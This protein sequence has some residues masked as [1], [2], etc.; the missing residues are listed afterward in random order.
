MKHIVYPMS[1]IVGQEAAKRALLLALVNP[2]AGGLLLSGAQGTAKTLLARAAG[3]LPQV[4]RLTQLPLG[5]TDDMV[6]GGADIERLLVDGVRAAQAGILQRA[7]GG[8]LL[9]DEANLLPRPF[10]HAALAAAA[11]D[12]SLVLVGTMNP[13]EGT[14]PA[15]V[16]DGFG[17]FVSLSGA[18]DAAER[19]AIVRRACAYSRA[20]EAFAAD[21]RAADEELG[22][23]V[24]AAR[25]RLADVVVS[26]A[27]RTLAAEFVVRARCA[28]NRAELF[29]TEAARAAAALAGRSYLLPADMEEAALY[30]LPHRMSA[31][32]EMPAPPPTAEESEGDGGQD[33]DDTPQE[34]QGQD[35]PQGDSPDAGDTAEED[36]HADESPTEEP[37]EES[38]DEGGDAD[39]TAPPPPAGA[40]MDT[41]FD[42]L[43]RMTMPLLDFAA[44]LRA[45]GTGSGKR[46]TAASAAGGRMVRDAAARERER[47]IALA[48]TLR[49]A[50]PYQRLR[51]RAADRRRIVIARSDLRRAVRERRRGANILFVVDAS[52][53][54]AARARMRA[55]KGAMLAL[56]R[57]AYVR[58]DRVGLV[59]FRRDRAETLLPLTRSVE[60][61]QRLLRELPTGGRTPL[62]AGLSEA[63]AHLAGAA[64]RGE[65]AETLLVVLT[66][67]RATAAPEGEDPA[68]AALAA[69]E[70][71]G[72][73]GVRALVLDTEQDFVRLHLA[74]QVAAKMHAPCYTLEELS[75]ERILH[76]V[77]VTRD[78]GA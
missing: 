61:A 58:R 49:A 56:L 73:T 19:R 20:P 36:S 53:S 25:E 66:D 22:A 18:D 78:F 11:Q 77:G 39:D 13:A 67:G 47:D 10:L 52:G 3:A 1:A 72:R 33:A 2:R 46:L 26:S 35:A 16:L 71:V 42:A 43:A 17:M 32:P 9:L 45:A 8:M 7:A 55:V 29:L 14:L 44:E 37:A 69:A 24:A 48:A 5:A 75:A 27:M 50:A 34:E 64:R 65:L 63:L 31:P 38:A 4:G 74:A 70:A 41:V 15:A 62:A 54:M 57:E 76:I 28:G 21:Y 59:A 12:A 51:R 23:S 60:L 40:G 30:V 68:Q 6:F